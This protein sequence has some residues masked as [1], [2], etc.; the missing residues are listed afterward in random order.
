[1]KS[2]L[3]FDGT[4]LFLEVLGRQNVY[5]ISR[6]GAQVKGPSFLY[7]RVAFVVTTLLK[8]AP[9]GLLVTGTC[10]FDMSDAHSELGS[11]F[12]N[13]IGASSSRVF[14]VNISRSS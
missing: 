5:I 14:Q 1:M 6:K 11:R 7:S 3:G 13:A 4:A 10:D 12:Q 2:F 9:N 8:E